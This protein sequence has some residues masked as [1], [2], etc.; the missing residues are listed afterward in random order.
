M[1]ERIDEQ[2]VRHVALLARLKLSEQET[3]RFSRELSAILD[4]FEQ[5]NQLDTAE[6]APT[7]HPLPI[8]NVLRADEIRPSIDARAALANAPQQ[9]SGFFRVPKVLDHD[10]A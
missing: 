10:S 1:S 4:Y 7:A 3:A 2:Q 9:E 6:V 5:L 8:C